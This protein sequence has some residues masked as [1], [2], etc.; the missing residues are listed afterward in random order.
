MVG[1]H[2]LSLN[3][4]NASHPNAN[5]PGSRPERMQSKRRFQENF[6]ASKKRRSKEDDSMKMPPPPPPTVPISAGIVSD[7]IKETQKA[8]ELE[9]SRSRGRNNFDKTL[10][11]DYSSSEDED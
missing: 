9:S 1:R 10:V 3:S 11:C 5:P 8:N 6:N 7:W 2:N 4:R